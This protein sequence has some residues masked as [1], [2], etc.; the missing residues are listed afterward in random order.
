M[1]F[2]TSSCLSQIHTPFGDNLSFAKHHFRRMSIRD[3]PINSPGFSDLSRSFE[4]P[5]G[6]LWEMRLPKNDVSFHI[7]E[8]VVVTI[9]HNNYEDL[10]GIMATSVHDHTAI[11]IGTKVCELSTLEKAV[12][13]VTKF[14]QFLR[15]DNR[16]R[17]ATL[18][19]KVDESSRF[20]HRA[21]YREIMKVFGPIDDLPENLDD[22]DDD[23]D[24]D[25]Y[26]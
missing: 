6:M 18:T 26:P 11:I 1:P 16:F 12:S 14:I 19:F 24:S 2:S 3:W 15:A 8:I 5:I 20:D 7:Y 23:D 21:L 17:E 25:Y 4:S 10:Y 9:S 22:D 13:R